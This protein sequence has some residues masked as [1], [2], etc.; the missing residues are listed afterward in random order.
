MRIWILL[1]PAFL[2]ACDS[3]AP[4]NVNCGHFNISGRV[5]DDR[6]KV[7][8]A[9]YLESDVWKIAVERTLPLLGVFTDETAAKYAPELLDGSNPEFAMTVRS[10]IGRYVNGEKIE[11]SVFSR[12]GA[13]EYY[14][15]EITAKK[16]NKKWQ[17]R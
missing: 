15:L 1:L 3:G 14:E 16:W 2:L 8:I 17:C 4:V 9:N 10:Y 13:A 7:E 5:W 6:A 11:F 12:K